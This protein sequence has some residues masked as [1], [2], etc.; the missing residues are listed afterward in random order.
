M[1]V[2]SCLR[3]ILLNLVCSKCM[4]FYPR[5]PIYSAGYLVYYSWVWVTA[6]IVL[7]YVETTGVF[8]SPVQ[9]RYSHLNPFQSTIC[10]LLA[11]LGPTRE[12]RPHTKNSPQPG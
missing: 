2:Y 6:K 10:C 1:V 5:V 8:G 11:R 7:F 3:Y 9:Q 12:C 4:Y